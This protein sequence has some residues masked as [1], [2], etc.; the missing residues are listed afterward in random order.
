M[1]YILLDIFSQGKL[2]KNQKPEEY[3]V[4]KSSLDPRSVCQHLPT[5]FLEFYYYVMSMNYTDEI[6][7]FHWK[8]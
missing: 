8:N 1:C 4:S 7:Y 5:I 2:L 3:E 6:N